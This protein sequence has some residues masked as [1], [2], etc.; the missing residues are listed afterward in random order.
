[1]NR[2]IQFFG[3]N[4]RRVSP[5]EEPK[6]CFI[7]A[8]YGKYEASCKKFAKQTVSTDF[9]CFTDNPNIIPNGWIIDTTPYHNIKKN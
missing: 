9:I 5:D 2:F 4:K 8:V 1:M 3:C 6:V 7:T